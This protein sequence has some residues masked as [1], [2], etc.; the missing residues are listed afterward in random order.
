V[1]GRPTKLTRELTARFCAHVARGLYP[2]TAAALEGIAAA[3][4]RRWLTIGHRYLEGDHSEPLGKACAGFLESMK[5]ADARAEA[6][7]VRQL[8]AH[9]RKE[10]LATATFLE[11]RFAPRWSR[12]AQRVEVEVT[13][14]QR[15][16]L[17]WP[18][19]READQ[20][21]ER[22]Q[23]RWAPPAG[24]IVDGEVRQLPAGDESSDEAAKPG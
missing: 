1:G 24:E 22:R 3:T 8:R 2:E 5:K 6:N 11:R 19:E 10:W 17:R 23:L 18:W 12:P 16:R 21:A 4:F 14:G 15:V 9:G 13:P 7:A 20:P